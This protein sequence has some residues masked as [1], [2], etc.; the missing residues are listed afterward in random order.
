MDFKKMLPFLEEEELKELVAKLEESPDGTY[1]GITMKQ[2]LPFLE[3]E[4]V[5]QM[6]ASA[7]EKG[8]AITSFL[9]YA[10]EEGLTHLVEKIIA[11]P[12]DPKVSLRPFLPFLEN[13]ALVKL[14]D[15][16]LLCDGS[17]G[18]L[19]YATLLPYM[20]D[21]TIDKSFLAMASSGDP[22]AK[23]LAPYAS[24]DAF[25]ELVKRYVDGSLPDFDI[26]SFYPYMDDDD[27]RTL[28]H[29]AQKD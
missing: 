22:M 2:V 28:F 27:I 17:Y 10:S 5:D 21:E 13:E 4:D 15:Q 9:P 7:Y 19:T 23:K 29:K 8:L 3:D 20:E 11:T 12:G 16:L 1:Q 25:H 26:D 6:I 14:A 18:D 24:D